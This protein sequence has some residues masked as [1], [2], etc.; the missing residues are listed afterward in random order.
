MIAPEQSL[1]LATVS[2]EDMRMPF[3]LTRRALLRQGRQ[4]DEHQKAK[5]VVK[6]V[7]GSESVLMYHHE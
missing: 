4:Q 7:L 1:I 2:S 5:G 6:T 3:S